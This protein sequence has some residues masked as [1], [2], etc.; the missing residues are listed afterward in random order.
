MFISVQ[1]RDKAAVLPV[2]SQFNDL[3]FKIIATRGTSAFL[4]AKGLRNRRINKVS[5]GRPHVVDAI[6]NGEI[7]FI[8]N[9]GTGDEPRRDGYHIRRAAIKFNIPYATTISGAMAMCRGIA[10]L[11]QKM[12]TV[13]T[14]QE[15]HE[16]DRS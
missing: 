1:D 14:V 9:T 7:Q 2:A 4:K 13:Q 12:L 11:K 5:I 3:G 16:N 10:A 8:I 15:Y 6:T